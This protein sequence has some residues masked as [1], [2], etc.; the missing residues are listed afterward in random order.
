MSRV[1]LRHS[2]LTRLLVTSVLIAVAAIAATAWLATATATRALRLEQGRSLTEDKGVYDLLVGYA[3]T[4]PDWS[5]APGL[6]RDRAAKIGRRITLTTPDRVVIAD[7]GPG[8]S[9]AGARASAT[10]DPLDLDLALSGGTERIDTRAA[11]PFLVPPAERAGLDKVAADTLICIRKGGGD[12]EIVRLP[13]G[14]P[15]IVLTGSGLDGNAAACNDQLTAASTKAEVGPLRELGRLVT[16]CARLPREL[17][18]GVRPDFSTYFL[19]AQRPEPVAMPDST[20]SA[21][22]PARVRGCVEKSRRAMLQ[23]YVAPPALL[24]VTDPTAGADQ[25]RFTLSRE[26][27]IR[28]VATTGG[29]LLA[30]I[31][32]TVLVGRRLVRPLRALTDAAGHGPVPVS[33]RDEIGRLARALNDSTERRDRAEAQRRAMVSDVAHEL[34][35][36]LT[37][38]RSWLEAAQDDL[39]PTDAQLVD[40][41]HEEALLLQHIIDDLS[42]LAGTLRLDLRPVALRDVLAQVVDSH[43]APAHAAGVRLAMEVPGDPVV[44]ADAVRL[45]QLLGNLVSNGIRYTPRGG[46]VTVT[47]HGPVIEVRDTGVGIAPENLPKIFDRFWRADESRS[48]ATGGS[49]LG[50]A[51]ARK[52]TEAHGGE[53]EVRSV[54]GQGTT[55]TVRLP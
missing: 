26:N 47:A 3:A 15:S 55:F 11:G 38:I 14:R 36:P 35:T 7:S 13:N 6:I 54:V 50:L 45:R 41:L 18:L 20:T 30:T 19:I 48:R 46:S 16:T 29:V 39:A 23:A 8:P 34:R 37:N 32:V 31:V 27:T 17:K 21:V 25:T 12:G 22:P 49:G 40:L 52:L 33:T 24:F 44:Q 5:G 43:L 1:P 53:I 42:D 2:L 51:I 10:V 9:L 28:I 4:H